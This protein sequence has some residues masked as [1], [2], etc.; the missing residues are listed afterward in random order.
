MPAPPIVVSCAAGSPGRGVA[1]WPAA[2]PRVPAPRRTVVDASSRSLGATK[3]GVGAVVPGAAGAPG[4]I[5][6]G[7]RNSV[8][9]SSAGAA[10]P[11]A[12]VGPA[13]PAGPVVASIP[14]RSRRRVGPA[15]G[16]VC[17]SMLT[18]PRT[19]VSSPSVSPSSSS[20]GASSRMSIGVTEWASSICTRC[21]VRANATADSY[22]SPGRLAM[23]RSSASWSDTGASARSR[24][25]TGCDSM[26]WMRSAPPFRP[27]GCSNGERPARSVKTVAPR[28]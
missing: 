8:R 26:R 9:S 17:G 21:R 2:S 27:P 20:G 7:P 6:T 25:G 16:F 13:M 11:P 3:P 23:A 18:M 4:A 12:P 28:A 19:R 24:R 1:G 15:A 22:R 14:T 10:S 5:E